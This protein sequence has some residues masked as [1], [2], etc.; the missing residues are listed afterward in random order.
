M[1]VSV[2]LSV[3]HAL[4]QSVT[5][6]WLPDFG[7]FSPRFWRPT[8]EFRGTSAAR[9]V[10]SGAVGASDAVPSPAPSHW[11]SR[12]VLYPMKVCQPPHTLCPAVLAPKLSA[13]ASPFDRW[14][15]S[16]R[17]Q[18]AE[19]PIGSVSSQGRSPRWHLEERS[20]FSY[21]YGPISSPRI[22]FCTARLTHVHRAFVQPAEHRLRF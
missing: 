20:V 17:S 2:R 19:Q 16:A 22:G 12:C 3:C 1:R 15:G 18:P 21:S 5:L 4:H 7:R 11:G 6:A 10:A 13:A 8:G 9:A 14:K